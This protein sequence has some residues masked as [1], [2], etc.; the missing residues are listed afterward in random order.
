MARRK[1]N[2]FNLSFLDIMS[3]GFGA[4][5]LFFMIINAQVA[6]RAERASEEL[7]AETDKVEEEVLDGRKDMVLVRS[8]LEDAQQE[9]DAN[10]A[11]IEEL[12]SILARLS[13]DMQDDQMD[14]LAQKES[15][16]KLKADIERLEDARKRLADRQTQQPSG[17][18]KKLR[19]YVGEGNRQYLTGL[20][21]GGE[22][23]LFLVDVSTSM[24]ARTYVNV[25]RFRSMQDETK[26]RAPKWLQVIDTVDWLTA[27]IAPGTKVQIFGFRDKATTLLEGS[28]GD[29]VEIS[30]GSELESAL[31][32]LKEEIPSGGSSLYNAVE[33]LKSMEPRPDNV[34][35]I[36]DGL[37]NLSTKATLEARMITA[38]QRIKFFNQAM[39]QVPS[40][41]PINVL[42]F[43]MDGDPTASGQ[44][45]SLALASGGSMIT[46]SRDWP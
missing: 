17:T 9:R 15:V 35:L 4:V 2:V 42:L 29:W 13:E 21:V 30:D 12:E 26:V 31:D 7:L 18:G 37:P 11:Q 14:A 27:Q 45:W 19:T 25:I 32:A 20:K 8:R 6:I 33:V 43:P 22:H 3:C 5:I 1:F 28:G 36:T 16:E 40:R 39:R 24:L 44:Y 34:Y 10:L 38:N 23:V 41:V 46:P